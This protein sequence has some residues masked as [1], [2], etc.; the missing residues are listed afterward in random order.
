MC[1]VLMYSIGYVDELTDSRYFAQI[2]HNVFVYRR[3][4][5]KCCQVH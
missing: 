5:R 4:C 2:I 1:T 3:L